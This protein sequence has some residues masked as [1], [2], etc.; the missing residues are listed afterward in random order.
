MPSF[1]RSHLFSLLV[2]MSVSLWCI[3]PLFHSGLFTAHD[4]W[5]QVARIY[6]YTE[7]VKDGQF[8]PAWIGQM[9]QG[10]GYPLFLFSYHFPWMIG[11]PLV[12][13]GMSVEGALKLLFAGSYFLSGYA[14]YW[15]AYKISK[16]S[17]AALCGAVLY[18]VAPFHFLS[19]YVSASIGTTFL[20]LLLPFVFGSIHLIAVEKRYSDGVFMG[21]LAVAATVLTHLM[22]IVMMAPFMILSALLALLSVPM[23]TAK[24]YLRPLS[25]YAILGI[26]A[27]VLTAFYLVPLF[28]LLPVTKAQDAGNG[29]SELYTHNLVYFK[30]LIYS[31]WGFGPIISDAKDGE[32]SL[33][34]GIAQWV[35]FAAV[36]VTLLIFKFLP[37]IFDK[38]KIQLHGKA[39]VSTLA[40]FVITTSAMTT[41]SK[42]FWEVMTSLVSVDYPFRLLTLSVFW[43]SLLSVFC[44]LSIKNH[45][46]QKI[47]VVG[48]IVIA[49]YTNRNHVRVN[50]YTH[51]PLFDYIQ[52]ETT[53]NTFNEYLPKQAN[54]QLVKKEKQAAVA[55]EIPAEVVEQTTRSLRVALTASQSQKITVRQFAFPGQAV[56][57][58]GTPASFDTDQEGRVQVAVEKGAHIVE[59]RYTPTYL[60][61]WTARISFVT[62]IV[63]FFIWYSGSLKKYDL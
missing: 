48:F 29:F 12:L 45:W 53:T 59:V 36:V 33:Q 27:F 58:N 26:L 3:Q 50:L 18:L 10:N 57:V 28:I 31:P 9:A 14:F 23:T 51:I 62:L 54:G 4:I 24:Q 15:Y 17:L 35:G 34:V 37:A 22:T 46:L 49:L 52:A 40:L 38:K 55:H 30:Q 32:I 60:Q 42:P 63:T 44:I 56:F 47:A 43:G 2:L 8:P 6:H 16:S 1:W 5:H 25:A 39:M 11:A 19:V 61:S 13:S 20:F 21:A 41:Y 7:A